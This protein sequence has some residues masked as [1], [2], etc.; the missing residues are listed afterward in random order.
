HES[1]TRVNEALRSKTGNH[2][3]TRKDT[4]IG[5]EIQCHVISRVIV[6]DKP[7]T[8]QKFISVLKGPHLVSV[9]PKPLPIVNSEGK[10][11]S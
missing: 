9:C 11:P 6:M 10:P 1:L 2:F 7:H 3:M 8:P 5:T 4:L